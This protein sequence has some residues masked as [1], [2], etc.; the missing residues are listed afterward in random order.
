MLME[1]FPNKQMLHPKTMELF[2]TKKT[3]STTKLWNSYKHNTCSTNKL[4][5]SSQKKNVPPKNGGTLSKKQMFHQKTME[6]YER[7]MELYWNSSAPNGARR[8]PYGVPWF[9]APWGQQRPMFHPPN[10]QIR[11]PPLCSILSFIL[12]AKPAHV[13]SPNTNKIQTPP[14]C[15]ILFCKLGAKTALFHPKQQK[16]LPPPLY[17]IL[18]CIIFQQHNA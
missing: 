11:T 12:G 10:K 2:Q 7:N 15:S 8:V 6:L 14:L 16:Q 18:C 17:A 5:N 13:P 4:W 3:C 1:L 9:W